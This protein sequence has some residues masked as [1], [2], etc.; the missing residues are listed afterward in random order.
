MM[1]R[2]H[3]SHQGEQA[4]LKRARDVLFWLGMSQQ[5]KEAV[6]CCSLCAEYAPAQPKEP[7]SI[8]EVP[9]R[10]WTIVAQDLYTLGGENYLITV[11]A[12]S[13]HWEVGELKT[14]LQ[15]QLSAK[16]NS[17]LLDMASRTKFTLTTA[18]SLT[19]PCT[20][21]LPKNGNLNTALYR[22]ITHN[23]MDW[24][25]LLWKRPNPF[26][27]KLCK[28]TKTNGWASWTTER[29]QQREWIAVQSRDSC[30]SDPEQ[31]YQ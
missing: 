19:A 28:P 11:D 29:R 23:P 31:L 4:C 9:A 2:I 8:P 27:I 20:P 10:P 30:Q 12:F 13:G 24:L 14:P 3:A 26:K 7:L 25:K 18:H 16:Q 5:I 22:H 17:I 15:V 6:S 1:K 21:S